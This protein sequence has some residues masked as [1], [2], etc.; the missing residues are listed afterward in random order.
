MAALTYVV[1]SVVICVAAAAIGIYAELG[2]QYIGIQRDTLTVSGGIGALGIHHL[3][4]G[5]GDTVQQIIIHHERTRF[6]FEILHLLTDILKNEWGFTGLVISDF[7]YAVHGPD[8]VT[9][10][11]DL[12]MSISYY[13]GLAAAALLLVYQQFLIA[14]RVPAHCF[15][16]F[17]NNHWVGALVFAGIIVHYYSL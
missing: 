16:A 2:R 10:G 14:D 4:E 12:E 8:A 1:T 5:L 6:R 15:L 13:L 11:L 17:L 3:T 7:V 9:A